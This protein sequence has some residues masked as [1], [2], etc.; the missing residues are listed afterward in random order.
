MLHSMMSPGVHKKLH[1]EVAFLSFSVSV[2]FLLPLFTRTSFGPPARNPG[3]SD[4]VL[5]YAS[6]P[7]S[8]PVSEKT[9]EESNGSWTQSGGIR[10]LMNRENRFPPLKFWQPLG[11]HFQPLPLLLS[12]CQVLGHKRMER[13][14][15]IYE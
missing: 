12:D 11:H 8:G 2:I 13:R 10:A 15:N 14:E 1:C 7:R 4:P 5:P 9:E 6:G 3:P